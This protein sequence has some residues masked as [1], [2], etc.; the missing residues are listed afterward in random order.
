MQ[1]K[2]FKVAK[3]YARA[4]Y[5]LAAENGLE[6]RTYEDMK[7]ADQVF[8]SSNELRAIMASPVI[9]EGKKQRILKGLFESVFHEL[10]MGYFLIVV[11]KQ[12]AMLL[13]AIAD[14]FLG[15]YKEAMGIE[16][17][18]VITASGLDEA[19]REKALKVA[20]HL[21]DKKIEFSEAIQPGIIGGFILHLGDRQYDA[22]IRTRLVNLRKQFHV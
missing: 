3:R 2:H 9:R 1:T 19:L 4:L 17:V 5:S 12:R 7:V 13:S 20:G 6:E 21:T 10:N 22:S 18:K 8:S 15:V 14:A 11:R 16:P